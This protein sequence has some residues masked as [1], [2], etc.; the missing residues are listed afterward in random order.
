MS[1]TM[2]SDLLDLRDVKR[3]VRTVEEPLR[4]W[5]IQSLSVLDEPQEIPVIGQAANIARSIF[6]TEYEFGKER[7]FPV[8]GL[9]SLLAGLSTLGERRV[10]ICT[11]TA[12]EH[13]DVMVVDESLTE[14]LGILKATRDCE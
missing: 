4:S 8:L 14:V 13:F 5:A 11:F 12:T 7:G 6:K 3:L 9:E 10:K 2:A 1:L